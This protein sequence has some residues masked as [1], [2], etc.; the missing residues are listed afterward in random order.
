MVE[1]LDA[2]AAAP[3]GLV[4]VPTRELAVQVAA[5]IR[6]LGAGK[7]TVVR[8]IYGGQALSIQ[9]TK[10][11]EGCHIVVGTPG[12]LLDHLRRKTLNLKR[13][14]TVVLDEADRMLD[15]GF[16][17]D[18]E[19][20]LAAVPR[21]RQTLLFSATI[22]A[23]VL[24]LASRH[25]R[26]PEMVTVNPDT[27]VASG[28]T[29]TFYAVDSHRRLEA[30]CEVLRAEHSGLT[31]VFCRTKREVDRVVIDLKRKGLSVCGLHGDYSQ[32]QR[33]EA[34]GRFRQGKVEVL[35]ATDL[36]ARGLDIEEVDRVVNY[37]IPQDPNNY[38]HR[39]G[40]TARA[41]R[42]G[43]A[44]S[45]VSPLERPLLNDIA[46][47]S[48]IKIEL[49][50]LSSGHIVTPPAPVAPRRAFHSG[51]RFFGPGRRR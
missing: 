21:E 27:P 15:M 20:I 8:P 10:L 23:Q 12:R 42:S 33:D 35:V 34:M 43:L 37:H 41:G 36:A 13:V 16:I 4:V 14:A 22:P 44:A 7:R 48:R 49:R 50:D 19:A 28:I 26:Q 6:R 47:L 29:H 3:V 18:I 5:E 30:L 32:S 31:L 40:R 45:L 2:P 9:I 38:L 11:K 39:T 17:E 1:K 25:L 24:P 46:K 51:H